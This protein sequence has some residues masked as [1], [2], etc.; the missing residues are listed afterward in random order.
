MIFIIV[1]LPVSHSIMISEA[2]EQSST[3]TL[4]PIGIVKNATSN[5]ITLIGKELSYTITEEHIF[6][7]DDDGKPLC[8]FFKLDPL[9]YIV[10]SAY[11]ELP[12]V[13]AYSFE[14]STGIKEKNAYLDFLQRDLSTRCNYIDQVSTER[15]EQHVSDWNY[16]LSK[17]FDHYNG[18]KYEQWPP[19]GSTITEG[20]I[21]TNWHQNPP[22]N[23]FC[24]ID[25]GSGQKSLAGCP[26]VTMAQILNFHTTTNDVLF[27]DD[28]DY[29][30]NYNGNQYWIDDDY[31]AYD[32][33]SFPQLNNYLDV[34]INH[35]ENEIPLTDDDKAALT[36]ACGVAAKQVYNPSG[37]GTFGVSQAYDAYFK[38]NFSS[39]ELLDENDPDLYLRLA[40]NMKNA[41]PAHLAIV[42]PGWTAGHNLVI[43]GYNTNDYFHLNFGWGGSY[44]GW[45]LLPS[46][47]PLDL[48]VV[49]GV[50]LD[51][52]VKQEFEIIQMNLSSQWNFV[53]LPCNETI[54]LNNISIYY[55]QLSYNWTQATTSQNPT[56]SPLI[57]ATTFGW[58]RGSQS[59]DIS[60]SLCGGYGY[61][62]YCYEP[63][64]LMVQFPIINA[65]QYMTTIQEQWN[66]IGSACNNEVNKTEIMVNET[67]WQDAVTY[68][69][70]E[71]SIFGWN[72][73]G[74]TYAL[75]PSL[76]P[77]NA[78]WTF[79]Y[80]R[81]ILNK[82]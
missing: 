74:Q 22:Y 70:V 76:M 50:I 13:I 19:E 64:A 25:G 31:I 54:D 51:I 79:A 65:D 21:E 37:S 61:W 12:P 60:N 15:I 14:E 32:F 52:I 11:Y 9:G 73:I 68:G 17:L 62:L 47:L 77:G 53:S 66:I 6:I 69:M 75:S 80:H 71:D 34:L 29:Y 27:T 42:N 24:P 39:I 58:N 63:C 40:N 30:H 44:N 72:A 8:Y 36:F 2:R 26:S 49:E 33:P 55:D 57:D 3:L 78:Y 38:F 67:S 35:Y 45:Y 16:L 43:D 81:C 41:T 59:Y 46:E 23:N 82:V 28:D 48:T 1:F 18:P 10:L 56:G 5:T 7:S 4:V 20:W